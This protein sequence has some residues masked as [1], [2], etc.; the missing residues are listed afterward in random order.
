MELQGLGSSLKNLQEI[1]SLIE[2]RAYGRCST[3]KTDSLLVNLLDKQGNFAGV[4]HK[5]RKSILIERNELFKEIIDKEAGDDKNPVQVKNPEHSKEEFHKKCM[6]M[7]EKFNKEWIIEEDPNFKIDP[8]FK[9]SDDESSED[10]D[11]EKFLEAFKQSPPVKE[12][13]SLES[14][15]LSKERS[16]DPI[17]D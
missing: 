1:G 9:E 4:T 14:T 6:E 15:D 2:L 17:R 8:N 12:S 3:S 16:M 10:S 5:S 7:L 11:D 13:A